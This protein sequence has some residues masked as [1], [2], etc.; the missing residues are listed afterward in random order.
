LKARVSP[1]PSS[2]SANQICCFAV[3]LR[4]PIDEHLDGIVAAVREHRGAVVV[5]EPGAGKTTRVPSRLLDATG[6]AVVCTQPRRIAAR[7]SAGRVAQERG[8]PLGQEIGYEVRFDRK[9]SSKTRLRFVT[10]GLAL[11]QWQRDAG[12]ERIVVL[13]EFHE[14]HLDADMLLA[15]AAQERE[16]NPDLA[17]V[18]M[19]ATLDPEP[20]ADF[21]GGVPILASEGR[22]YPVEIDYLQPREEERLEVSVSRAL[23]QLLKDDQSGDVLV[24]LPGLAEIRRCEEKL[25]ELA[26]QRE[27][28][29]CQLHG[30]LPPAEQDKAL[31]P[32]NTRKVILA[33][34]VAETSVTI[35]GVTSV[36]D[37]GTARVA[38]HSPWT[39]LSSLQVEDISQA[40][41][42]QRAGRAGRTAAG[43]CLRLYSE[44]DLR[45]RREFDTPEIARSDLAAPTLQLAAAGTRFEEL[46]W[47]DEAPERA[48]N[49]SSQLLHELGAFAD[50]ELS[51]VGK[52]MSTLPVHPRL[53][54]LVLEAEKLGVVDLGTQA[55]ALLSERPLR[56]GQRRGQQA[57]AS[58]SSDVLDDLDVLEELREGKFR[59]HVARAAGADLQTARSVERSA[60]QLRKALGKKSRAARLSGEERDEALRRALLA[61]FPD[62][63]CRRVRPRGESLLLCRGGAVTQSRSSAVL[64][65]E[66]LLA[67][68]VEARG[69]GGSGRGTLVRIASAIDPSWLL[70]LPGVRDVDEHQYQSEG[71]RVVRRTGIHYGDFAIDEEQIVDPSRMDPDAARLALRT[72]LL[73]GKLLQVIDAKALAGYRLRLAF[74]SKLSPEL[75]WLELDDEGIVDALL[76][77]VERPTRLSD[78]RSSSVVDGLYWALTGEQRKALDTLAPTHVAIPGRK[79]VMVNYEVDR[80]PWIQSRLQDFFGAQEGPSVGGGRVPLTLHLLAPN[81]RAVQVTTDLAGFWERHYPALRKQ[82][83]RRYPR[84]QWPEKP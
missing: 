70:D 42:K 63:A 67:I 27:L 4:L 79:R 74:T 22:H 54:R 23:R 39:G 77:M 36:I 38:R 8:S 16:K 12:T 51:Q 5:A 60:Q 28:L 15:L 73:D 53:A 69:A 84:H 46:Q 10:E 68:D 55:A 2:F 65:A 24:F 52:E 61:A 21:L 66:Y 57:S 71:E 40:S 80:A 44:H 72:A 9:T 33:T 13:D 37:C 34:N 43:H 3:S 56:H 45:G 49:A 18:I 1:E 62:R 78:L 11:R 50:Q 20:I 58:S 48:R 26:G 75:D 30:S 35:E 31:R 64:D 25:Q 32:S 82:L 41:A 29:L 19:S 59:S 81:R 14:R 17:L 6:R 47:L 76:A 7:L 83:M